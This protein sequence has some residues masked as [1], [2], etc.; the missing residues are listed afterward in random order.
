[1][2]DNLWNIERVEELLAKLGPV[3]R[4]V[5]HGHRLSHDTVVGGQLAAR[6]MVA[7]FWGDVGEFYAASPEIIRW[8]LDEN[9]ELRKESQ[10]Y[11]EIRREAQNS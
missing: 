5:L 7:E 6:E 9:A 10:L 11:R 4:L 8:L 3:D 1:M 2:T